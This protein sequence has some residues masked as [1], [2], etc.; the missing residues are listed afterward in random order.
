[1]SRQ[2]PGAAAL[3]SGVRFAASGT[4]ERA[5]LA[6]LLAP[7]ILRVKTNIAGLYLCGADAEPLACLSGRAARIAAAFALKEPAPG[8]ESAG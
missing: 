5:S 3:V 7:S 1:L 6:H 2:V 8:S 4:G